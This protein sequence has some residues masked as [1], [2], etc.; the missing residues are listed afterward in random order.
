MKAYTAAQVRA[1]EQPLLDA[2]VP[3][4]ERAAAALADEIRERAR[5]SRDAR[6]A[7]GEPRVLLVVGSG[8]NGGDALFAGATVASQGF[9]VDI[10]RTSERIHAAGLAAAL[11]S[12]ARVIDAQS[13]EASSYDVI[14]DA[15]LGTGASGSALRGTA[16]EV[17]GRMLSLLDEPQHPVIVACDLPSGIHP[18]TGE[19][20]D[21]C[22]LRADVTVTFGAAK[23]GMLCEPASD[24]VG[25]LVVADIGLGG[26]LERI[27]AV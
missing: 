24:Y 23:T 9:L 15:I 14:V 27:A 13:V 18:D 1:A 16:R 6:D 20:P 8:N 21:P 7:A 17:V 4:M 11:D 2:G 10:V 19:V 22:L 5:E 26:E 3:L 12:G 25:R